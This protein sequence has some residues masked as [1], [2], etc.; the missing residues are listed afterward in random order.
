MSG[1][2]P[3]VVLV[4]RRTELEDL[5]DRHGTRGQAEF[6]LRTRGRDLADVQVRHDA[7]YAARRTVSGAVPGDWRSGSVERADLDRFL[8]APEDLVVAVGQDGLVANLAK[9][10]AGQPVIGVDPEPGRHP[11]VLV[12]HPAGAVAG[13]LAAVLAGAAPITARTM[14]SAATDDGQELTALNELYLGDAS[15]QTARYTL[16]RPDGAT[17]RQGSSGLL[18]GT[19]TGATGWCRSAWQERRSGLTLPAPGDPGLTWFVREAWPSPS[20]GTTLIEGLLAA[21]ESL[22]IRVESDALVVFGDGLEAD[23]LTATW[24]QRVRLHRAERTLRHVA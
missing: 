11:G 21:G 5:V 18:V 23:R 6:F 7:A 15:H 1:L 9:Y 13:L 3:R 17:E 16:T 8:F 12:P 22:E 10:L 24:G 20:T 14:V 4:H 2:P 19:G